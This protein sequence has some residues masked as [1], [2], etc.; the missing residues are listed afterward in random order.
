ML[1][2]LLRNALGGAFVSGSLVLGAIHIHPQSSFTQRS[3]HC[4]QAISGSRQTPEKF[5]DCLSARATHEYLL[6]DLKKKLITLS[7]T[8]HLYGSKYQP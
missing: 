8:E 7:S 5:A 2:L 4:T 6:I 1:L 3:L